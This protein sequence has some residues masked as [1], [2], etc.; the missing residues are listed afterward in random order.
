MISGA[1][2]RRPY[3]ETLSVSQKPKV[4][5]VADI[6]FLLD[7]TSSMAPCIGAVKENIAA[8]VR[9]LTDANANAFIKDW[10]T[11]IV[12]YRDW[13]CDRE[14]YV[15][16]PFVNTV[17]AL[18][19]QLAALKDT[20]GGD[21]PESLLEALYRLANMPVT[22]PEESRRPDAW[23]H[24]RDARRFVVVFT[25]ASY[26]ETMVDPAGGKVN[27]VIYAMINAKIALYLFAPDMACYE[28]LSELDQSQWY[29]VTGGT[30]PQESLK[31]F[32]SDRSH[33]QEIMEKLARTI[34]MTATVPLA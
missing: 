26:H 34:T 19:A 22:G 1:S 15:D 24:G 17:A 5:G 7:A 20:G 14:P 29:P 33:F 9:Q 23:R 27:D 12:G 28:P 11:K 16:N 6:V 30:T 8:F 31:A 18:E 4:K 13:G 10:R 32:V 25:D 3:Q 21:E 2:P